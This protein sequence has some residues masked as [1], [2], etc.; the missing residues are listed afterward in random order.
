MINNYYKVFFTLSF[1]YQLE[2][3]KIVSKSFKSD[4]DLNS[5]SFHSEL[6]DSNVYSKWTKYALSTA[7][8]N[9]NP[10]SK[11]NEKKITEKK[12]TTHR[13]INLINLTEVHRV[14][15]A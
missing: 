3:K 15:N 7:V 11:F 8:S 14:Q 5:L 6:K 2:A 1:L 9:L 10:P 12:I 13:I 4:V